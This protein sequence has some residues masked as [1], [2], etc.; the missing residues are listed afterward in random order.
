MKPSQHI[1]LLLLMHKPGRLVLSCCALSV[2]VIIMFVELG[3]FRGIVDSQ[4]NLPTL[5]DGDL[6]VLS[7]RRVHLNKFNK[8]PIIRI[9]QLAALREVAQALP[10]YRSAEGLRNPQTGRL[11]RVFVYA[12]PIEEMP[13]DIAVPTN[14][15]RLLNQ[16]GT[17]LFDQ[18][19]RRIYGDLSVG[20]PVELGDR[21]YE[22]IGFTRIGPNLVSDGNVVL[23]ESTWLS[24]DRSR[25]P[26][27]GVIRLAEGIE[28]EEGRRAIL[29][30]IGGDLD[31]F[32]PQELRSREV[33]YTV[34][35]APIG[36]IF[37]VGMVA[38]LVIGV[39]IC[40][41]VLFNEINDHLTQFATLRAIGF[42]NGFLS[43]IVVEEALI[44]SLVGFGLGS[45]VSY[46]LYDF[47]AKES[48]MVMNFHLSSTLMIFGLSV[49]MCLTAGLIAARKCLETQPA[50][51][52]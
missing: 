40:Y 35:V 22:L 49:L 46:W 13:F 21:T 1:G 5:I 52:Y 11:K 10:V 37:A 25:R 23:S 38:G 33:A 15:R 14:L 8:F 19:S 7:Q 50:D 24:T 45:A 20:D 6:V 27:M 44:V 39:L 42:P 34:Q 4:S 16:P 47:I 12:F 17:L 36:L 30:A 3:L 32:T 2:A 9:H 51:L 43:R 29:D 28:L 18:S 48:A 26:T 41:Q 31:V